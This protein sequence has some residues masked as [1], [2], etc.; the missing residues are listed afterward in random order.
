MKKVLLIFSMTIVL[1][2]LV[3][4]VNLLTESESVTI[5]CIP[6]YEWSTA[7]NSCV[8]R[9]DAYIFN[10]DIYTTYKIQF[11]GDDYTVYR[12]YVFLSDDTDIVVDMGNYNGYHYYFDSDSHYNY[13]IVEKDDVFKR[14]SE[15]ID[16][17]WFTL[18]DLVTLFNI[19][20]L[21]SEAI[22]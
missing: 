14:L 2:S 7:E 8:L 9:S 1:L 13:Y 5:D 11:E 21:Q 17:E 16:S 6:G 19:S 12:T 15:A 3:G 18:E 20:Q 4:C 10:E 22:S